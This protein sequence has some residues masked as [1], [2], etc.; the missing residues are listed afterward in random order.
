VVHSNLRSKDGFKLIGK[1][2]SVD[3]LSQH[4]GEDGDWVFVSGF[5]AGSSMGGGYFYYDSSQVGIT[6]GA[7]IFNGWIRY[8]PNKILTTYDV[9]LL[10]DAG[11]DATVR[12]QALFSAIADDYTVYIFGTH[13]ITRP[14]SFNNVNNVTIKGV[15]GCINANTLKNSFQFVLMEGYGY[16]AATAGSTLGYPAGLI[17]FFNCTNITIDKLDFYGGKIRFNNTAVDVLLRREYGD[18]GIYFLNSPGTEIK[19]CNISHFWSWGVLGS[20]N[21]NNSSVHDCYVGNTSLQSGINIFNGSSGNKVYDNTIEY[22]A[23]YG[24][25]MEVLGSYQTTYGNIYGA[26]V[27]NN[28]ISWC[29]WGIT[30][31]RGIATAS[32]STNTVEHCLYAFNA[33]NNTSVPEDIVYSKN[34][35]RYCIYHAHVT[36]TKNTKIVG[37]TISNPSKPD[38]INANQYSCIIS[39]DPNDRTI[40]YTFK[41]STFTGSTI[42]I[43]GATYT[44]SSRTSISDPDYTY[45]ENGYVKVVLTSPLSAAA[46]IGSTIFMSTE[47]YNPFAMATS[48]AYQSAANDAYVTGIVFAKNTVSGVFQ[49][50][51]QLSTDLS[52][53]SGTAISVVDNTFINGPDNT[54]SPVY[55]VARSL[56][57]SNSI[58]W[59]NN[60]VSPGVG[61]YLPTVSG[62][63]SKVKP[64]EVIHFS[65]P[66][67]SLS[68]GTVF[69]IHYFVSD[70]DRV[71][72]GV[73][74]MFTNTSSSTPIQLKLDGVVVYPTVFATNTTLQGLSI[75]TDRTYTKGL[76]LSANSNTGRHN[77]QLYTSDTSAVCGGYELFIYL[78]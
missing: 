26:E 46:E 61:F 19:G 32:I 1:F 37:N 33:V 25:E 13:C 12:L 73:D 40:F 17:S 9:G 59:R 39:I 34:T 56:A 29:K 38:Y 76:A 49:G 60:E 15:G 62:S 77:V 22:C 10:P 57:W 14:I 28:K 64:S 16:Y 6:N 47:N 21:C 63:T 24:V 42:K 65:I 68:S 70:S 36:G 69:P 51:V 5:F 11:T 67:L 27:Y 74:L 23:L 44:V 4:V 41:S 30:P 43:E 71:V 45:G 8:N 58:E 52:S 55:K 50:Y 3:L 75:Y 54:Y 20:G 78:L 18:M 35:S 66:K 7:T 72:L 31:V 48:I 53:A 2:S